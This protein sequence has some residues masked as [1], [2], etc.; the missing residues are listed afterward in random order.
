MLQS[1]N[2]VI[3]SVSFSENKLGA[4][5]SSA[6]VSYFTQPIPTFGGQIERSAEDVRMTTYT[7]KNLRL[8]TDIQYAI[9]RASARIPGWDYQQVP[10]IDAWGREEKSGT[11]PMRAMDN[12]LNPAYTSSMQVTDVDKEIQRLYNQTGDGGVVPDRP[13]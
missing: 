13:Q 1:L 2:D 10:Y 9:G 7:D 8:P 5:V 6:L 11:L 4:L 12:F 3:D